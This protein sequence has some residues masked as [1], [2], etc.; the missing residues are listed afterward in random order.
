MTPLY[1]DELYHFGVKGMKW[2]VKKKYYKNYMDTDRVLKKGFEVQNIS[3]NE[4]RKITDNP[5]YGA[6][7]KHDK[8]AYGG[9]YARD[10][11]FYG[12]KA[13]TNNLLLTKD[14]KIPSQKKSLELF[15]ELYNKDPKGVSDSIGKA[16][17]ELY[18]FHGIPKIR[19]Y[20]ANRFS[21]RIQN[22]G[23]EWV[24]NKGYLMF[25]QSMMATK[26]K[27][28]RVKYYDL[29]LKKG[30]NAISD[31]NDVQSGYGSDDPIIFI[32]PKNT[33]KNV[34]SRQLTIEEVELSNARYEYDEAIKNSNTISK[35]IPDSEYN[36]A[37]RNLKSVEKKQGIYSK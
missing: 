14:V 8:Q 13:Y 24:K 35:I 10:I 6:H 9:S 28:A 37:R 4:T 32:N 33:L 12:D 27:T 25:N 17:S 11:M 5:I 30:Y 7:T 34:K 23:E 16:Y 2:G 15:M 29:L 20:N 31:I 18:Y 21:K 3:R 19:E 26:E 1:N 36:T 22:K